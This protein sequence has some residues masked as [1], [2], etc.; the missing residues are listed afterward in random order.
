MKKKKKQKKKRKKKE[1]LNRVA[2]MQVSI[3]WGEWENQKVGFL[4]S[5]QKIELL[6]FLM[7]TGITHQ[8]ATVKSQMD[9]RS[10]PVFLPSLPSNS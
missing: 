2:R 8:A 5:R 1:N 4:P 6:L 7:K 3:W 9:G 10:L